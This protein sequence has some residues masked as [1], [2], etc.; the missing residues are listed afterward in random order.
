VCCGGEA[1]NLAAFV[2]K[3]VK[4]LENHS[5]L[6]SP[7]LESDYVLSLKRTLVSLGSAFS[8][9]TLSTSRFKGESE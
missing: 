1:I 4:I 2:S 3:P 7:A 5:V 6:V 8:F 9:H